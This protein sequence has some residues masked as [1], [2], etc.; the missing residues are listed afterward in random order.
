VCEKPLPPELL[1]S[2]PDAAL[3]KEQMNEEEKR[4][5]S[6]DPNIHH[7]DGGIGI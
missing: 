1:F 7:T 2:A 6:F 3:L 4:A 5:K